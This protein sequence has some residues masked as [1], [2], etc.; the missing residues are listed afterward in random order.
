MNTYTE[1]LLTAGAQAYASK[2]QDTLNLAISTGNSDLEQRIREQINL[3]FASD[4]NGQ[5]G[6]PMA[7]MC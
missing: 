6:I 4:H 7:V 3:F 1:H 2:L 5:A